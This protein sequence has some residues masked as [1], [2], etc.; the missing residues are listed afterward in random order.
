MKIGDKVK[1]M[2]HNHAP[3]NGVRKSAWPIGSIGMIT[4][5]NNPWDSPEDKNGVGIVDSEGSR[6]WGFHVDELEPVSSKNYIEF[7]TKEGIKFSIPRGAF[8]VTERED[9]GATIHLL[10]RMIFWQVKETYEE[11]MKKVE[12]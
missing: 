8:F 12:E 6:L 9:G 2:N 3:N 1:V 7:T 4:S 5:I 11:V 10:D